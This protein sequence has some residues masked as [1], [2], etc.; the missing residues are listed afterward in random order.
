MIP[1]AE[2]TSRIR[3]GKGMIRGSFLFSM[4]PPAGNSGNTRALLQFSTSPAF[5]TTKTIFNSNFF[6]TGQSSS[7]RVFEGY[8]LDNL[9]VIPDSSANPYSI[10]TGNDFLNFPYGVDLYYRAGFMVNANN[11]ICILSGGSISIIPF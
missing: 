11:T 1:A 2:I 10:N 8:V 9:F 6:Q 5:T 3:E 7:I 4:T